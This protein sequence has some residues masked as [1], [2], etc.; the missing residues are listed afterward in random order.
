VGVIL[1][2]VCIKEMVAIL[3]KCKNDSV[4]IIRKKLNAFGASA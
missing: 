3:G 2:T 1:E 4:K